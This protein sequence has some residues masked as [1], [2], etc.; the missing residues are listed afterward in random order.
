M[1]NKVKNL[2]EDYLYMEKI[3]QD[4]FNKPKQE[5]INLFKNYD[6]KKREAA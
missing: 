2:L 1:K 5:I 6:D 4:Q 3:H